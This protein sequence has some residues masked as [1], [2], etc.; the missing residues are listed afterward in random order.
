MTR[1]QRA[2]HVRSWYFLS[3]LL[4]VGLWLAIQSRRNESANAGSPA[5]ASE[6]P[7]QFSRYAGPGL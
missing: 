2:W 6:R 5:V 1:L 7:T 3:A 4:A